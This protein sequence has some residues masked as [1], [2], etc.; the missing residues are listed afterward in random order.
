MAV[1]IAI[2]LKISSMPI[3][4]TPGTRHNVQVLLLHYNL[5]HYIL[6]RCFNITNGW[7]LDSHQNEN[8]LKHVDV[9]I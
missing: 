5:V 8:Q 7:K 6:L 1:W 2:N 4:V 9:L 3:T